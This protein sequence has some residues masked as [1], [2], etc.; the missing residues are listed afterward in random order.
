VPCADGPE[1]FDAAEV[2]ASVTLVSA[3]ERVS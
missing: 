3:A 1:I 2:L